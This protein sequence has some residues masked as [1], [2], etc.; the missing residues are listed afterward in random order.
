MLQNGYS[1]CQEL[2]LESSLSC[3]PLYIPLD[4][5][6]SYQVVSH[7]SA[8]AQTVPSLNFNQ[9]VIYLALALCHDNSRYWGLLHLLK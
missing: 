5:P 1:S 7:V 4:I 6:T 8:F 3:Y 9:T 2:E